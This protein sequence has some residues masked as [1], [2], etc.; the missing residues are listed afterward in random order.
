MNTH[1]EQ[2][3]KA[4]WAG[5]WQGMAASCDVFAPPAP[6]ERRSPALDLDAMRADWRRIGADFDTV[7]KKARKATHA[8][9]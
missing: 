8:A 6:I 9:A 7:I 1:R 2:A 4:F 3:R 5:F